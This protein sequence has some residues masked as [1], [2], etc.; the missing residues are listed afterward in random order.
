MKIKFSEKNQYGK[1]IRY[2]RRAE[3]LTQIQCAEK[4]GISQAALAQYE[5]GVRVPKPEKLN[6]I[7]SAFGYSLV[8]K[9]KKERRRK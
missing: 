9:I 4:A 7:L 2:L 8:M 1:L 3:E 5:R 6:Q